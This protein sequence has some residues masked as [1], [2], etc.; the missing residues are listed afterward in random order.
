VHIG[1]HVRRDPR[2]RAILGIGDLHVF[3]DFSNPDREIRVVSNKRRIYGPVG[4]FLPKLSIHKGR[5]ED[6]LGHARVLDELSGYLEVVGVLT[7]NWL[8]RI[9]V[10]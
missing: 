10:Y 2:C 9:A 1:D 5:L 7:G 4:G 8:E 3:G 6:V